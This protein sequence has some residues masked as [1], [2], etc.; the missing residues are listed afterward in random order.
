MFA[1]IYLFILFLDVDVDV[2]YVCIVWNTGRI[3]QNVSIFLKH[4]GRR[5]FV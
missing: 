4:N 1:V 5:Y 3:K 2:L